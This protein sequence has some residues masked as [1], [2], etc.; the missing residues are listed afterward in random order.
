MI[1]YLWRNPFPQEAEKLRQQ[2]EDQKLQRQREAEAAEKLRQKQE[3]QKLQRVAEAAEK[4]RQQQEAE[5]LQRQREKENDDL[6]SEKGVDYRRLRDL[7]KAEEWKEA[8]Q[9]TLAVMLKVSRRKKEG[10]LDSESIKNF[11]CTDLRTI[12]QLWVKYSSGRFGFSVQKK[13]W[14][15]VGKKENAFCTRVGWQ[16]SAKW[17]L[18]GWVN[19]GSINYDGTA[20]EGHLPWSSELGF[21]SGLSSLFSRV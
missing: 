20:T 6:S 14:L 18:G 3:A 9:E 19:R 8:D 10:W 2:E 7:L 4:L 16:I 21:G 15:E 12:D 17:F 13:I 1:N 5:K 11:P